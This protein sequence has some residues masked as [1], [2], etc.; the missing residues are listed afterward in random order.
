M[1]LSVRSVAVLALGGTIA[2]PAAADGAVPELSAAQIVA[3][4]PGLR[5][6]GIDV[7]V[8][9]VRRLPSASLSVPD[10]AHVAGL[11]RELAEPGM[12]GAVVTQGTDT[13]EETAWLLDLLL[14]S[15]GL[16]VAV[17]G[18]MRHA[19]QA[20]A[21]G[22]ANLLAAVRFAASR[23]ARGLGVVVVFGDEVY[24]ARQVRKLHSTGITAFGSTG[25]PIG[26]VTEDRVTVWSRPRPL[27]A[28]VVELLARVRLDR[29]GGFRIPVWPVVLADDGYLLR[30][31]LAGA[32]AGGIDGLVVA[33]VGV[34]HVPAGLAAE[35][36]ALA[37]SVPVVL[38]SR[39]G[40][41][42]VT[43]ATYGY[44]GSETDLLSRGLIRA[45]HLDPYK[46][47]ILL[48]VLLAAGARPEEI[49]LAV[50][51]TGDYAD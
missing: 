24:P 30:A 3:A 39:I 10:V 12:S 40:A 34:G 21:D 35:L 4:V 11:I 43:T 29:L 41:G 7:R 6:L 45:G 47:R 37:A 9:D 28:T 14:A 36:G 22:P 44:P 20:G 26:Q 13:I 51:A 50:E 1:T 8:A 38:A 46:A 23:R 48:G 16:P 18:A 32:A 5:G 2:S 25:G 49:A 15:D 27:P 19:G 17:T 33:G 31:A 42:P